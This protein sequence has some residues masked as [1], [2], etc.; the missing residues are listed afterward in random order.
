[1]EEE[2]TAIEELKEFATK[3]N[4]KIDFSE[5]VYI[6]S[7]I[8]PRNLTKSH[9]IVSDSANSEGYFVNYC[10]M[11]A[12]G[13][14]GMYSGFFFPVEAST[15]SIINVR[16]KN[17]LDKMNPFL[18]QSKFKSSFPGFNSKVV[19]AENDEH[20]CQKIFN[21]RQVNELLLEA[22]QLD[23]RIKV[24]LNHID[25]GIVPQLQ[26]KSC[27]GIYI[28]EQWLLEDVTIEKLFRLM[29][30]LIDALNR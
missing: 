2:K 29:D 1:M 28:T 8:T 30:K 15:S 17:I 24:G 18:E 19:I 27:L 26:N 11:A 9:V 13:D 23:P 25:V 3:S 6:A 14:N 20:A 5:N 7:G 4:R 22:L 16:S 21:K 10:D 12:W